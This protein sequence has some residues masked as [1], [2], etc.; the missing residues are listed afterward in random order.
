MEVYLKSDIGL[1]RSSN[2]DAC[3]CGIF[4]DRSVWAVVCDGMGG[5]NGG[6]VAS[7]VA[8]ETVS[9][10]LEKNYKET[11]TDDQTVD[12]LTSIVQKANSKLYKMQKKDAS[13]RGMG[14]TIELALIRDG[15]AHIVHAGDS[16]VY[17]IRGNKIKQLTTDHSVVQEMVEKGEITPEQARVH[18]NKN[19]ITRALGIVPQIHLD[20]IEAPFEQG[21]I[22]LMCSDGLSN[23]LTPAELV[24]LSLENEGE[25]FTDALVESAKGLGGSDNITVAVITF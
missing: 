11:L 24:T 9:G 23:Y 7:E 14:T 1:V 21:D 10:L 16:R 19:Y 12:L 25:A 17:S 3:K 20:Y 22:L 18:P 5:A 13:L 2:Q 4:P 15:A 6:N 8:V